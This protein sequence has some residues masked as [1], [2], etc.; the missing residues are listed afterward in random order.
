MRRRGGFT[1]IEL[2][3][4]MALIA[5]LTVLS[6]GFLKDLYD[7]YR[8]TQSA[9]EL[10]G[11]I[12]D[13]QS[14]ARGVA[15]AKAY[16]VEIFPK[17]ASE[18]SVKDLVRTI[19]YADDGATSLVATPSSFMP[20]EAT[21]IRLNRTDIA[22]CSLA[23]AD[24]SFTGSHPGENF[25]AK[26]EEKSFVINFSSPFGAPEYFLRDS[27]ATNGDGGI[28][29]DG[30]FAFCRSALATA[31]IKPDN[32]VATACAWKRNTNFLDSYS[33][34]H[35]GTVPTDTAIAG[36]IRVPASPVNGESY[37]IQNGGHLEIE[38]KYNGAT[39][40]ISVEGSG[41]AYIE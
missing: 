33:V 25:S 38:I 16:G 28:D 31:E 2:M 34:F 19:T 35:I 13:A 6:V 3:V 37:Y 22:S 18:T 8:V 26:S 39:R 27:S 15:G 24:C 12:R 40:L 21:S 14:K 4:V 29:D 7:N 17:A 30:S 41:E 36:Q 11:Y 20:F 23:A 5:V 1:I 10:L 9:E 32:S